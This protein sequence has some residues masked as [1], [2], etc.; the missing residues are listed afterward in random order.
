VFILDCPRQR[1]AALTQA[2]RKAGGEYVVIHPS[3]IG[4][5]STLIATHALPGAKP[6]NLLE[7]GE[8]TAYAIEQIDHENPPRKPVVTSRGWKLPKAEKDPKW[9]YI[10]NAKGLD[11]ETLIA[12][13]S[14]AGLGA[15]TW[16]TLPESV[17]WALS[18]LFP[19]DWS[20]EQVR[21]GLAR[22]A[23]GMPIDRTE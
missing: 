20:E 22:L 13:L 2:V 15:M 18:W 4:R 16:E 6:L 23:A 7:A 11:R 10:T 19:R 14:A 21:D 17:E 3:G 8:L 12:A 1:V 9:R 5:E